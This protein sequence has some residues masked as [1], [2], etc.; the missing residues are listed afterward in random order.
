MICRINTMVKDSGR[1]QGVNLAIDFFR[2]APKKL[3]NV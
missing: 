3:T 2:Q 1:P